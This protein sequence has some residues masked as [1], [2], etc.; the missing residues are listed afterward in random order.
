MNRL[1]KVIFLNLLNLFDINRI[2]IAKKDGV[3]S[4]FESKTIVTVLAGL[5][6]GYLLYR[7]FLLLNLSN[8]L[9]VL[10]ISFLLST[11]LC[12]FSSLF[13]ISSTVLKCDDNELLFS[14]PL[15]VNQVLFSKLFQVYLTNLIYSIVV[16]FIGILVYSSGVE[17]ISDTFVLMYI[18]STFIIPFIPIVLVTI[19]SYIDLICK[20]KFRKLEYNVGK[21]LIIA[22]VLL[23]VYL[24]FRN[25][26]SG[27]INT[28][29][30]HI[31]HKLIYFYPLVLVFEKTFKSENIFFFISL[32][33]VPSLIMYIFNMLLSNQ[34]LSICSRLKGVGKREKF[35]Y[36]KTH[37][38]KRRG[39]L[40][41]KELLYLFG[42]K[43]YLKSTVGPNLLLSTILIVVLVL[44]DPSKIM[45][46]GEQLKIMNARV[47]SF[48]AM[49]CCF[50]VTTISSLSLEKRNL[51]LIRSFPIRNSQLLFYKWL[52]GFAL[53]SLFGIIN[54]TT[55]WIFL[56]LSTGV[57]ISCYWY[58]IASIMFVSFTGL[59]LDYV[60]VNKNNLSD[61]EILKGR[62]LTIVPPLIS[63]VIG[64]VPIFTMLT[65]VYYRTLLS[66]VLIMLII[67]VLEIGYMF[68][69]KNKLEENLYS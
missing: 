10:N 3:K 2:L 37:S 39:G 1:V 48:I 69:H 19:I 6:Y 30:E 25:T 61:N 42:N 27:N 64:I 7:L 12:F 4:G 45:G 31:Y 33:A 9:M 44:M 57:A 28:I 13:T 35:V 40:F 8:H 49:M 16:M 60:F 23:F 67:S 29:V 46:T 65:A 14:M 20:L 38:L 51:E 26:M 66:Y 62:F 15:T 63:I 34:Y 24:V 55:A 50:S 52:L 47:P 54:A 41:R 58:S 18:L 11:I 32:L 17:T 56:K 21:Y 22:C 53:G 59:F 36:K 68:I 43:T 5:M